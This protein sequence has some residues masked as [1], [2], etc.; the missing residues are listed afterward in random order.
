MYCN[1]YPIPSYNILFIFLYLILSCSD[2]MSFPGHSGLHV[3]SSHS[4][5][6]D[7]SLPSSSSFKRKQYFDNT[8]SVNQCSSPASHQM[9]ELVPQDTPASI[10]PLP[11]HTILPLPQRSGDKNPSSSSS[12]SGNRK[13][14]FDNVSSGRQRSSPAQAST[15]S[16]FS[17][18]LKGKV[19]TDYG[20]KC[21]H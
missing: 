17:N 4:G 6:E 10:F 7:P 14:Q 1:K 20:N 13:K 11:T 2:R 21:W 12:S 3:S 5:D 16:D 19:K 15:V 8:S 18:G 9:T